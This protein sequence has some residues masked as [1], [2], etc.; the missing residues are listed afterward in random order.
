VAVATGAPRDWA[1]SERCGSCHPTVLE[2]WRKTA[3]ARAGAAA[4]VTGNSTCLPCHSTGDGAAP[5]ARFPGVG[6]ESCH[7]AGA[8]YATDDLMRDLPLSRQLGLRDL[9]GPA[10]GAVCLRCHRPETA[11]RVA[12][13]DPTS[14][15]KKIGH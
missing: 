13:F 5:G 2:S 11:T 3:H 15:W 8:A 1:G 4:G 12:P 10:L 7:G 14:A 6:C 9:S